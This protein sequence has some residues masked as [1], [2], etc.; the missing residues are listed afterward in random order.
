MLGNLMEK[1]CKLARSRVDVSVAPA[2][3]KIAI[4]IADDGPGVPEAERETVLARGIR[5]DER[6]PGSGLGLGIAADLA[7]LHGGGLEFGERP[8][9]GLVVILRLPRIPGA[10]S[11]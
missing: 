6:I 1:A 8:G 3:G 9:G 5:L 2:D 7:A 11:V 10:V 4:A